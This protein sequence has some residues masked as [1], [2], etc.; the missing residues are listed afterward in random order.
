MKPEEV[1]VINEDGKAFNGN[2]KA[3]YVAAFFISVGV[4]ALATH[5]VLLA[6]QK[7]GVLWL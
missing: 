4:F 1:N 6:L 5:L 2:K 7:V 3:V